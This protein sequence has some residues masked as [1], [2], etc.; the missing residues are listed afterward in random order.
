[1]AKLALERDLLVISDECYES[2]TYE[3][4]HVSIASLSPEIKARTIVVNTCSKAYA[5]T[6]WRIGYA[7]GPKAIIRAMTDVQSQVTSNPASVAAVGRGGGA[8]RSPG[9]GGQD[10]GRVRPPAPRDRRR[11]STPFPACGA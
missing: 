9:R 3:G 8:G 10:G 4:R 2:L 7:A 1:M 5:M 6:G 11:R